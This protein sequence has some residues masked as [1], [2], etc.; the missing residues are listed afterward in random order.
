M[1]LI[2][3]TWWASFASQYDFDE[4]PNVKKNNNETKDILHINIE[5]YKYSVGNGRFILV[6]AFCNLKAFLSIT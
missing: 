2:R 5:N 3:Y 1:V 4:Q 6:I